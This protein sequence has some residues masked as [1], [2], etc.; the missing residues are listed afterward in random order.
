MLQPT[1][2]AAWRRWLA[3]E[4]RH[5]RSEAGLSQRDVAKA[6]RCTVN[7]VA[8]MEKGYRPVKQRDLAEVLLP[9]YEVGDDRCRLYLD[10]VEESKRKGWWEEEYDDEIVP[11]WFGR[12]IGLE[13]GAVELRV[14][15]GQVIS[16]LLQT[17]EYAWAVEERT[18]VDIDNVAERV[19]V[20]VRRSAVL[21]RE[22]VP[23]KFWAVLDEA[24]L[25]R[26]VGGPKIMRAQLEHLVDTAKRPNVTI[27]VL[28]FSAGAHAA[29]ESAIRILQFPW[30]GDPGLA[31]R[32]GN[33]G[34]S[35]V[36]LE[37]AGLV[38]DHLLVFEQV[39]SLALGAEESL[40]LV[41]DVV[42][43]YP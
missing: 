39:S 30:A 6:L 22:P 15:Q 17:P 7:K 4:L 10:A 40:H 27:Q 25:R 11:D 16:G 18:L 14:F 5:L 19:E 28:P 41:E 31:Y 43:D 13:Q 34:G 42:N 26:V 8:Y 33:G 32:E 35:G 9:L 37:E 2:P 3:F 24:A 38:A 29:M 1:S 12:Y 23:L 21:S 36:F 20:R